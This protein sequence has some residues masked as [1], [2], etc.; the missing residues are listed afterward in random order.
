M[1]R[2]KYPIILF[3]L[4]VCV[5]QRW[6]SFDIFTSGDWW[7]FQSTT[8][9]DM[10]HPVIWNS[11]NGLGSVDITIWRYPV[12]SF[13]FG[14]FGQFNLNQEIA[15]KIT[16]FWPTLIV[17]NLAI[18]LLIARA[19]RLREFA[20]FIGTSLFNY[21]TY[22][23][24]S[25]HLLLF[26]SAVWSILS[27]YFIIRFQDNGNYINLLLSILTWSIAVSFDLRV[28]YIISFLILGYVVYNQYILRNSQFRNN[29]FKSCFNLCTLVTVFIF[30]N[31]YWLLPMIMANSLTENAVLSRSLFGN[32]FLNIRYSITSFYPFWTGEQS[33][34]FITQTIP[35]HYWLLPITA[36]LGLILN[37][38]KPKILFFGVI[39]LL[40]IFLSKQVGYPFTEFYKAL[41]EKFPGFGAFREATK[42]YFLTLLGYSILIASLLQSLIQAYNKSKNA[43]MIKVQFLIVLL[44]C[45][46]ILATSMSPVYT[47]KVKSYYIPTPIPSGYKEVNEFI[48]AE[49][50]FFRT[51]WIP[52][53]PRWSTPTLHHPSESWQNYSDYVRDYMNDRH[54]DRAGFFIHGLDIVLDE[55][56]IRYLIVPKQ[57]Y[58]DADFFKDYYPRN[59]YVNEL[60]KQEFLKKVNLNIHGID[61]YENNKYNPKIYFFPIVKAVDSDNS[62]KDFIEARHEVISSSHYHLKFKYISTPIYL[63]LSEAYHYGWKIRIGEHNWF[64]S[65]YIKNYYYPNK[66]HL[67]SDIGLN[68]WKIDPQWLQDQGYEEGDLI[69]IT[70]YFA[71]Q[72]WMYLGL[73]ISGSTLIIM[74]VLLTYLAYK[75]YAKNKKK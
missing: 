47:G 17:G 59:H 66:Y 14:I 24:G 35:I 3:L 16:I 51:L 25:T 69:P 9:K 36:T 22:Y 62:S 39:A 31:L 70:I 4:S 34:P 45:L 12:I 10:L 50:H 20:A 74:I 72:A 8:M 41:F 48:S 27:L 61:I 58:G 6:I 18:Y 29:F 55:T 5:F 15:E 75:D 1:T 2:F 23:L 40:G 54:H 49:D 67:E 63:N 21:S 46:S 43:L 28:G 26:S 13:P 44:C 65:L 33:T 37:G 56:S 73:I 19:L 7:Y 30:L 64:E 71:P 68:Y 53:I 57:E 32:S 42:F 38:N 60:D 52:I 11:L